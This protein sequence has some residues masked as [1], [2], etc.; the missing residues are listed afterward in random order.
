MAR[1]WNG[2]SRSRMLNTQ[3]FPSFRAGTVAGS[4]P[5]DPL[6]QSVL[7]TANTARA[8]EAIL[9][10]ALRST[11]LIHFPDPASI[12]LIAVALLCVGR[13]FAQLSHL[14]LPNQLWQTAC[15]LKSQH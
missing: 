11:S 5:R 4:R 15:T 10:V 7:T 13:A 14:T 9:P 2:I 8:N 1:K 3:T 6:H 12:R